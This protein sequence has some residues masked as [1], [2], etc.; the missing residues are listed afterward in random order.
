MPAPLSSDLRSRI[1]A[2]WLNKEGTWVELAERF[3]VGP[4]SVNRLIARVRRTGSI[5]P[6]KQKYGSDPKLSEEHLAEIKKML[7][8]RPD[9]TFPELQL[10]I[11]EKLGVE[12]SVATVGRAVRERLG[13]TRKK[14]PSCRSSGTDP[15]LS[16]PARSSSPSSARSRRTD[17]SSSTRA[18]RTSG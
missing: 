3:D 4:A 14:S 18:A 7:E 1:I 9:I 15:P 17:S 2:A 8:G 13:W 11:V 6:T 10:E 16:L 12:V 5:E